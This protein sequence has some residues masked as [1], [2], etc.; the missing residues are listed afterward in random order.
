MYVVMLKNK[1]SIALTTESLR[2]PNWELRIFIIIEEF[3]PKKKNK[4]NRWNWTKSG[5]WAVICELLQVSCYMWA[6]ICT[7]GIFALFLWLCNLILESLGQVWYFFWFSLHFKSYLKL[8]HQTKDD[9][10][11][12]LYYMTE[13]LQTPM[14][15]MKVNKYTLYCITENIRGCFIFTI[16]TDEWYSEK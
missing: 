16:F 11:S 5:K 10:F 9:Y 3:E 14:V 1:K 2:L 7:N 4:I 15:W 13:V 6:V 8:M 12:L